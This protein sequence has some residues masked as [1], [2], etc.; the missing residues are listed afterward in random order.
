MRS[1]AR[2]HDPAA[3]AAAYAEAGADGIVFETRDAPLELLCG[4][5]R[6]VACALTIPIAIW[7]DLTT[8]AEIG[9]LL[10]A[11]AQQVVIQ[12]AALD[13]PDLIASLAREF[14]SDTI[15]VA[16]SAAGPEAGW[17]VYDAV[18]GAAREWDA[19]TWAQVIEAQNGGAILLNS[20]AGG[21]QGEP[22]DLELLRSV[23]SAVARPVLAAGDAGA[24]EDLFDALMIGDVDAVLVT[25][26]LHS[27]R[28]RVSEIKDYLSEH[29]LPVRT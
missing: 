15:V 2:A 19:V 27:G 9:A 23:S 4:L 14:G 1:L 7:T 10:G 12:K 29:G 28:A 16:V 26:L 3:A 21:P 22:Y 25:S 17:R 6:Q 18:G 13:D 8:A 5:A 24:V 11:G 20:P